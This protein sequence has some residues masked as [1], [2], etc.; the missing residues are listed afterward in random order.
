ME[1]HPARDFT[2]PL[3]HGLNS[4]RVFSLSQLKT[5]LVS[6]DVIFSLDLSFLFLLPLTCHDD[7]LHSFLP[8]FYLKGFEVELGGPYGEERCEDKDDNDDSIDDDNKENIP[9]NQLEENP[10][11]LSRDEI[12]LYDDIFPEATATTGNAKSDKNKV[13]TTCNLSIPFLRLYQ[14]WFSK[15]KSFPFMYRG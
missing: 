1:N 11:K 6:G 5:K 13:L 9:D 4:T 7:L 12:M 14:K 10:W 15:R 2:F 3:Q 8:F